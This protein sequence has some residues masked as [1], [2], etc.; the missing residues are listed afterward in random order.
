VINGLVENFIQEN[1]N[2]LIEDED[3]EY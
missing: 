3:E 1:S 2:G